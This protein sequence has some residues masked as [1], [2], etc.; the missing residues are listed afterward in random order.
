MM[1]FRRRKI[2][3]ARVAC[4]TCFMCIFIYGNKYIGLLNY[5][6][7]LITNHDGCINSVRAR[8]VAYICSVVWPLHV[9]GFIRVGICS[10]DKYTNLR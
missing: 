5:G 9:R 1:A 4:V 7:K 3:I 10:C 2:A 6:G 8:S